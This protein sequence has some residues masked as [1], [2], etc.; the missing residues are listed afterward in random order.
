MPVCACLAALALSVAWVPVQSQPEKKP[1]A[2]M[3]LEKK[4]DTKPGPQVEMEAAMKA[5]TP[6]PAHQ[7]LAKTAGDY[8]TVTKFRTGSDGPAEESTGTAR[9]T[10]ILDGRFLM[11]ANSGTIMGQPV[12]R[13][14]L[15]GYNNA[16]KQY[17]TSWVYTGST[18]ILTMTGTSTDGGKTVRWT[19][20]FEDPVEGKQSLQ[21]VTRQI[22]EDHFVLEISG[23]DPKAPRFAMVETTYTR[24]K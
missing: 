12:R 19:G 22:D 10:S 5:D 2:P 8:T 9:I 4:P 15:S 23:S 17:E 3:S 13:L 21:A 14:R 20:A 1:S 6:G 24:K 16:T 11:E 7:Q 18:A